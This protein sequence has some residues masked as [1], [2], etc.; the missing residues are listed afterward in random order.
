MGEKNWLR[1]SGDICGP[2]LPFGFVEAEELSLQE[3][4]GLVKAYSKN[5]HEGTLET[6]LENN[7]F[8]RL[9]LEAYE[10]SWLA[11]CTPPPGAPDSEMQEF[12]RYLA[13][14]RK[15]RKERT[16]RNPCI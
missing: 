5:K 6:W 8:T 16:G 15:E 13:D 10:L 2:Q 12:G 4:R 7:L 1:Y 14:F 3:W 11:E 9:N